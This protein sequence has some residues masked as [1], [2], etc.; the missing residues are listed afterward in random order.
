[1]GE[2]R[3]LLDF[4]KAMLQKKLNH[5]FFG[6]VAEPTDLALGFKLATGFVELGLFLAILM[7]LFRDIHEKNILLGFFVAVIAY[8]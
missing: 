8:D 6:K 4:R 1:M 7:R 3:L 2:A 5:C